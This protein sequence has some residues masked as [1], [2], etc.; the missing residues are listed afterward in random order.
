MGIPVSGVIK[1]TA[2]MSIYGI[3]ERFNKGRDG[4]L[5]KSE[6]DRLDEVL[7]FAR[8]HEIN[9]DD[10]EFK[11]KMSSYIS[12]VIG[13]VTE[14]VESDYV[15]HAITL[16]NTLRKSGIELELTY[17]QSHTFELL[18]SKFESSLNLIQGGNLESFRQIKSL[19]QLCDSIELT[20]K[21]LN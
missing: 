6:L 21:A 8:Q 10:R 2:E 15:S 14:K 1:K 12:Q 4:D 20:Q 16:I 17:P 18:K 11:N 3:L 19:I 7:T 5:S 9:F 13:R